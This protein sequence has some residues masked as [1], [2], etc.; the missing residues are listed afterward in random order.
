MINAI[1]II[2]II[3][4]TI[5]NTL[6][7]ICITIII[8]LHWAKHPNSPRSRQ[9]AYRPLADWPSFNSRTETPNTCLLNRAAFELHPLRLS[10]ICALGARGLFGEM[11][12]HKFAP[13]RAPPARA[14]RDLALGR[15]ATPMLGV[16]TNYVYIYIYKNIYPRAT[17]LGLPN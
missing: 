9:T 16:C 15:P 5:M 14:R 3:I 12:A 6:I 10:R 7:C 13:E 4:N 17:P 2:V 11:H 8:I 1:I